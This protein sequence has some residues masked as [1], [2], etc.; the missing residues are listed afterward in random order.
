MTEVS[1]NY[2]PRVK[3]APRSA[4]ELPSPVPES[5][6]KRLADIESMTRE[7]FRGITTDGTPVPGLFPLHQTGLPLDDLRGAANDLV[8]ALNS[9]Q[10]EA[11]RFPI[12]SDTWRRW[13]NIHAFLMRHGL[14]L[15][16][17]DGAQR[18]AALRLLR[19]TLSDDGY[20]TARDIMRLNETIREITGSDEE[21]GDWLY[22]V[23]LFGEPSATE[24]WG[25]QIDGHHLNLNCFVLGG[26][27]V[28]TPLFMGS[29]PV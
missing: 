18:E 4:R 19:M 5:I 13:S 27:M 8:A 17:L 26:Q 29:E 15:E 22:W 11:V 7:P 20:K 9:R 14:C 25:W 12:D 21:Y 16:A 23:S 10:Q 6:A 28:L 2:R 3:S 24:P 1:L